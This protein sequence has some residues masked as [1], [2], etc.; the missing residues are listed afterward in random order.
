MRG[1]GEE[2]FKVKD[3]TVE[4]RTTSNRIAIDRNWLLSRLDRAIMSCQL[5]FVTLNKPN[6]CI[7]GATH[8]GGTFC[9]RVQYRLKISWRAGDDMQDLTRGRLLLQPFSDFSL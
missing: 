5:V 7:I 8:L 2:I 9:N 4:D 6:H 3:L 1:N